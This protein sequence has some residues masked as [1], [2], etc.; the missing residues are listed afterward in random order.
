ML[1]RALPFLL[2]GVGIAW[3]LAVRGQPGKTPR[4]RG[5]TADEV[6]E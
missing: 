4:A 5:G 1:P 6:V 2:T 3:P